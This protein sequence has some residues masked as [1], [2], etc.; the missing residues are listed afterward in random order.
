MKEIAA[1]TISSGTG[2]L[3]IIMS[4]L[5]I[6]VTSLVCYRD[7]LAIALKVKKDDR[8][9]GKRAERAMH[10]PRPTRPASDVITSGNS[11]DGRVYRNLLSLAGLSALILQ[12]HAC[13]ANRSSAD[14]TK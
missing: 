1:L 10:T 7:H 2:H 14:K 3:V 9:A 5:T 12:L 11:C 6:D 8:N 13:P 4:V